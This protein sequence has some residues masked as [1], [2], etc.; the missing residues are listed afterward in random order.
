MSAR[1]NKGITHLK[2]ARDQPEKADE[3]LVPRLS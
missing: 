2:P 3:S 1:S